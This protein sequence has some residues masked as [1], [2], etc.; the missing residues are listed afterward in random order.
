MKK[1]KMNLPKLALNKEVI[2][3]LSQEKIA[4]GASAPGDNYVQSLHATYL[5]S[6][7]DCATYDAAC[8]T[9]AVSCWPTNAPTC[10]IG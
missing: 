10:V 7:F 6:V 8:N 3:S 2:S 9:R 5:C 1:K 4:G